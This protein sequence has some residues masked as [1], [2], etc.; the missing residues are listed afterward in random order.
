ML[1][2]IFVDYITIA[3]PK[4][5]NDGV[6]SMSK[7]WKKDSSYKP[8]PFTKERMNIAGQLFKEKPANSIPVTGKGKE[9]DSPYT[10]DVN[11]AID[12]ALKVLGVQPEPNPKDQ[13]KKQSGKVK[14]I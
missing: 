2:P 10:D 5:G 3:P 14:F 11:N 7:L 4:L 8:E 9:G 1:D 6:A 13:K 12:T